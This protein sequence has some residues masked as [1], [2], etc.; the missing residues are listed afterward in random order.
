MDAKQ[1]LKQLV[2]P[3]NN[4][5]DIP[6]CAFVRTLRHGCYLRKSQVTILLK[7]HWALDSSLP[8]LWSYENPKK[9]CKISFKL[10]SD[11]HPGYSWWL[12]WGISF[13]D[14]RCQF[15]CKEDSKRKY[16]ILSLLAVVSFSIPIARKYALDPFSLL[17]KSYSKS[18][19]SSSIYTEDFTAML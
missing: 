17:K 6:W 12:Y 10:E 7:T 2:D 13:E 11:I 19:L 5:Y 15:D 3:D 18:V 8:S 9:R 4:N 1:R 14:S 16:Q